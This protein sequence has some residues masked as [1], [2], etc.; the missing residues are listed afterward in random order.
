MSTST[1][2][3]ISVRCSYLWDK[4]QPDSRIRPSQVLHSRCFATIESRH[5]S[6][7]SPMFP[8]ATSSKTAIASRSARSYSDFRDFSV[9]DASQTNARARFYRRRSPFSHRSVF[10]H[11]QRSEPSLH[12]CLRP[13]QRETA[14]GHRDSTLR[15][16]SGCMPR[17]SR[18]YGPPRVVSQRSEDYELSMN[19]TVSYQL[20]LLQQAFSNTN[21]YDVHQLLCWPTSS[22]MRLCTLP[23][24]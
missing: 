15:I 21:V 10:Y 19:L 1:S 6:R 2:A 23:I 13:S 3:S 22:T 20:F 4:C 9:T 12:A 17:S 8:N 24:P 11:S 16:H 7:D 18:E 14:C 5:V